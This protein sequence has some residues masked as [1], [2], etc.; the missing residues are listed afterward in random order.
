MFKEGVKNQSLPKVLLHPKYPALLSFAW[1]W[2]GP[3]SCCS[4]LTHLNLSLPSFLPQARARVL[5]DWPPPWVQEWPNFLGLIS[6]SWAPLGLLLDSSVAPLGPLLVGSSWTH[7]G[8]LL[9]SGPPPSCWPSRANHF[10][11]SDRLTERWG[12]LFHKRTRYVRIYIYI[13]ICA[14]TYLHTHMYLSLSLYMYIHTHI[15]D[16]PSILSHPFAH[17]RLLID[18]RSLSLTSRLV[19][20]RVLDDLLAS[21]QHGE[22]GR[23]D[24]LRRWREL[25][26]RN[27]FVV[28]ED[29]S[30]RVGPHGQFLPPPPPQRKVWLGIHSRSPSFD[31]E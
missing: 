20:P 9:Y 6:G 31:F 5:D 10:L 18:Q 22:E 1:F 21:V 25:P 29:V 26:N 11:K 2:N 28:R 30:A 19:C 14:H 7:L 15:R 3:G 12:A 16:D 13:Y 27:G 23:W 17:F 8:P 4:D 24:L